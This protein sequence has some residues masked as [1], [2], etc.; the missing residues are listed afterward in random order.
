MGANKEGQ[1]DN[2]CNRADAQ[3]SSYSQENSVCMHADAQVPAGSMSSTYVSADD[4]AEMDTGPDTEMHCLSLLDSVHA[5][6]SSAQESRLDLI[7]DR[8]RGSS[9]ARE[10]AAFSV[11]TAN[12]SS[13]ANAIE[14]V[15]A[16]PGR[17]VFAAQV[18]VTRPTTPASPA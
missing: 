2:A 14:A 9:A 1:G 4:K 6:D 12:S 18:T 5:L 7:P 13:S 16:S 3:S 11:S 10:E 17:R 8:P 15:T